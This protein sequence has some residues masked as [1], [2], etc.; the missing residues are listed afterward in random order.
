MS[1]LL[2]VINAIST[3][4]FLVTTGLSFVVAVGLTRF[5]HNDQL[6]VIL[7]F[8]IVVPGILIGCYWQSVHEKNRTRYR[9]KPPR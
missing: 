9:R 5:M 7:G 3:W 1:G 8:S 6:K 4:R 2:S